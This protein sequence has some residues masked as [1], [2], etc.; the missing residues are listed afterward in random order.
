MNTDTALWIILTIG[1]LL[2]ILYV[3]LSLNFREEMERA[4]GKTD[5]HVVIGCMTLIG[6]AVNLAL[7][8]YYALATDQ[9]L[10]GV[11]PTVSIGLSW[12]T[13]ALMRLAKEGSR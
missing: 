10:L 9:I 11:I 13:R 6:G 2:S 7:W 3:P 1:T 5:G 4:K 8:W 12:V